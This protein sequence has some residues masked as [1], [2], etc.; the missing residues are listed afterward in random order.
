[1]IRG[2]S[3]VGV[4]P[5]E[6]ARGGSFEGRK[7]CTL[8][9][10]QTPIHQLQ[11]YL[12]VREAQLSR[13]ESLPPGFLSFVR[14]VQ[15]LATILVEFLDDNCMQMAAAL[16]YSSLLALVPVTTLFFSIFTNFRAFGEFRS[17]I[18]NFLTEQLFANATLGHQILAQLDRFSA[19]AK[20]LGVVAMVAL[21]VTVIFLMITVENSLNHVWK[22]PPRRRMLTRVITYSALVFLGPILLSLSFYL[23]NQHLRGMV[24]G[25]HIS[26]GLW[27]FISGVS[28]SCLMFFFIYMV[29]PEAKVGLRPAL[30]GGMVAGALF[31]WAKWGFNRY[32][33]VSNFYTNVY[34]TLGIVPIFLVWLYVVWL[35]TLLGMEIVYVGQHQEGLKTYARVL[36]SGDN[37]SDAALVATMCQIATNFYDG[38]AEDSNQAQLAKHLGLPL[39][40]VTS[41]LHHLEAEGFLNRIAGNSENF[42]PCRPIDQITV[43]ELVQSLHADEILGRLSETDLRYYPLLEAFSRAGAY[44]DELFEQMTLGDIAAQRLDR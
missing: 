4:R 30:A 8:A 15:F 29:V 28:V 36:R 31:E 5:W 7:A 39:F 2:A 22:I 40:Y 9:G 12:L 27:K 33:Q 34:E 10:V 41:I 38:R 26:Q 11:K 37:V 23:T 19:N 25:M 21:I 44:R 35:V 43:H 20:Q 18:E 17:D 14:F 24:M 42:T 3:L 16:A 6:S 32:L 13:A 1:M